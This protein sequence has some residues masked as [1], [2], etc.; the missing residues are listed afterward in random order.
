MKYHVYYLSDG[1]ERQL[2]LKANNYSLMAFVLFEALTNMELESIYLIR[3]ETYLI[4]VRNKD[5]MEIVKLT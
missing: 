4:E 2:S 5:D 3:K 1:G